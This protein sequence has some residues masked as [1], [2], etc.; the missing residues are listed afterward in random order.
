LVPNDREKSAR[1]QLDK[2]VAGRNHILSAAAST[3]LEKPT[4]QGNELAGRKL[5]VAA[6]AKTMF[7]L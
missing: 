1:N 2:K 6:G 4:E 3:L 7:G 5:L